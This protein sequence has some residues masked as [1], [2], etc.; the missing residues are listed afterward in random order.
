[1]FAPKPAI[2][3]LIRVVRFSLPSFISVLFTIPALGGVRLDIEAR[4]PSQVTQDVN[5]MSMLPQG[6]CPSHILATD[7]LSVGY[8]I[9]KEAYYVYGTA[10]L[11]RSESRH[12]NV[13]LRDI[14][15]IPET[16]I[17]AL[18]TH[19]GSLIPELAG[20][21]DNAARICTAREML[22]TFAKILETQ[23]S[24]TAAGVGV[25]LHVE[26]YAR[27]M[28]ALMQAKRTLIEIE[29]AAISQGY[30]MSK[31]LG[32]T[33]KGLSGN[34]LDTTERKQAVIQISVS[35][36][37]PHYTRLL[38][39]HRDLPREVT[40]RDVID[41]DGLQIGLRTGGQRLFLHADDVVLQPGATRTFNVIVR[42][43]WNVNGPRIDRLQTVATLALAEAS[44]VGLAV[45]SD[46]LRSVLVGVKKLRETSGPQ[47][48]DARYV[49]FFRKQSREVAELER[50]LARIQELAV[51]AFTPGTNTPPPDPHTT[52]LIIYTILGFLALFSTPMYFKYLYANT[53][54]HRAL[55]QP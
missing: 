16:E 12:F 39:I 6:I 5:I 27:N 3:K 47:M 4:N 55:Q 18:R 37:S 15:I 34:L 29:N 13:E 28:D 1:M 32:E 43:R 52:W 30:T 38:D 24:H 44:K 2:A 45:V 19:V 53:P 23:R 21:R 17:N 41:S 20:S 7:G 31:L 8:D 50:A 49:A 36:Q 33:E 42:D 11:S 25:S 46:K 26:T 22:K 48:L 14:W 9:S 10:S 54:N 40:A 35:N 51:Q